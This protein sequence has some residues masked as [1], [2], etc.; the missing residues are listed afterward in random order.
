MSQK[1]LLKI[2]SGLVS[3]SKKSSSNAF[4]DIPPRTRRVIFIVGLAGI[5]MVIMGSLASSNPLFEQTDKIIHF[6]GYLLLG[7]LFAIGLGAVLW[8]PAMAALIGAGAAL[9]YV[10]LFVGRSFQMSDIYVNSLGVAVGFVLGLIGRGVFAYIHSEV[11]NIAARKQTINIPSGH[12]IFNKG[13][14]SD[15]VYVVLEGEVEIIRKEIG[16]ITNLETVKPGE[17][18]GEMGVIQGEPR[19]ASAKAKGSCS[20]FVMS[21]E[22]LLH[23]VDGLEHPAIPVIRV[24]AKRLSK[25]DKRLVQAENQEV[26]I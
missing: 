11:A 19:F 3:Q 1:P 17:V 8:I 20:L 4:L 14:P 16:G 13:D 10:Q 6:S 18:F 24:L 7:G 25:S 23:K 9:E 2:M 5:I 12:T 21:K 26:N 22:Q 15:Y